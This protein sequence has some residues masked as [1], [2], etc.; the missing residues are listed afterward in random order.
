MFHDRF[1]DFRDEIR[2]LLVAKPVSMNC[3]NDFF[4]FIVFNLYITIKKYVF[5]TKANG[6]GGLA[7]ILRAFC[8]RSLKRNFFSRNIRLPT[9]TLDAKLIYPSPLSLLTYR[10]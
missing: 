10:H 1:K 3:F 5:Q 6:K 2:E 9:G 8:I 7:E 4:L